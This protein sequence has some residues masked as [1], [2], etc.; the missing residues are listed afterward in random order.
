MVWSYIF[1]LKVDEDV[2][3]KFEDGEVESVDWLTVTEIEEKMKT[4][5]IT[6]DSIDSFNYYI[7]KL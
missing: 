1:F 4:D 7:N 5:K 6:P 2:C 3:I